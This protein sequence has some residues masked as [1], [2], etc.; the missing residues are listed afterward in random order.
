MNVCIICDHVVGGNYYILTKVRKCF[1]GV[2]TGQLAAVI[3]EECGYT[4]EI[5][6]IRKVQNLTDI[7]NS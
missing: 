3:C 2:V 4:L 1:S 6:K 5:G 7:L